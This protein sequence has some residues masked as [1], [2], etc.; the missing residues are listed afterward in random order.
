MNLCSSCPRDS[1]VPE[2][3]QVTELGQQESPWGGVAPASSPTRDATKARSLT[4]DQR[5]FRQGVMPHYS[6]SKREGSPHF[7][8]ASTRLQRAPGALADLTWL[9]DD[10]RHGAAPPGGWRAQPD[11]SSPRVVLTG[12]RGSSRAR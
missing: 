6:C 11:P 4:E 5:S 9:G 12:G 10:A 1:E 8:C 2:A 7:R 3:G